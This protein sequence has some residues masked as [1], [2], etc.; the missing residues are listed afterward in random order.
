HFP[1]SSLSLPTYSLF[2]PPP[3][4][5]SLLPPHFSP[6][7]ES[8]FVRK[9]AYDKVEKLLNTIF[10]VSEE[11]VAAATPSVSTPARGLSPPRPHLS[12]SLALAATPSSSNNISLSDP[13]AATASTLTPSLN[14]VSLLSPPSTSHPFSAHSFPS[15]THPSL[16]PPNQS[17]SPSVSSPSISSPTN[18]PPP[19]KSART[20]IPAS[21]PRARAATGSRARLRPPSTPAEGLPIDITVYWKGKLAEKDK[22]LAIERK[23]KHLLGKYLKIALNH[24]G[25][26]SV[27]ELPR[28]PGSGP[29]RDTVAGK[30]IQKLKR[31]LR[32][33]NPL[34]APVAPDIFETKNTEGFILPVKHASLRLTALGVP[35]DKQGEVMS[36]GAQMIG[37]RLSHTPSKT[38]VRSWVPAITAL[39]RMHA[40]EKLEQCKGGATLGRDETTKKGDK[41]QQH[42]VVLGPNQVLFLGFTAVPDKS[43]LVSFDSFR[44][45]IES[46]FAFSSSS[47]PSQ[48]FHSV[49]IKIKNLMS[50]RASTETLF[51]K[52]FKSVR[53]CFLELRE[54]WESLASEEQEEAQSL[55]IHF[56]Q[57]HAVANLY[58]IVSGELV[59]QECESRLHP[60]DSSS[61]GFATV[62]REIPRYLST[63]SAGAHREH[64]EWMEFMKLMGI[65]GGTIP[66]LAGHRFNIHFLIAARVFSLRDHIKKF[67][68]YAPTMAFLNDLLDDEL[69]L[70]QV[71]ILGLLDQKITGPLWRIAENVGVIEGAQ[72]HRDIL[73]YIDDCIDSPALFFSGECPRMTTPPS[74]ELFKV[75]GTLFKALV[76]NSPSSLALEVSVRVLRACATYLRDV[77]SQSLPGG[78]YS[79]P[80]DSV[81]QCVQS[82]TTNRAAESAFAFMDYLYRK[83]PNM[84]F[85]RRDAIT[86]FRLNHVGEW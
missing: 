10:T 67:I 76:T 78:S 19:S 30:E 31:K 74:F 6:G 71:Q 37:V 52:I 20:S 35:D 42:V 47:S 29:P 59:D 25:V 34:P 32:Q 82:P 55:C 26:D 86:C 23:Q 85:F 9:R 24:L 63:R 65:Q 38:T 2:T 62:V 64:K 77:L 3:T 14:R 43:A 8:E 45:K 12:V 16:P 69:V 7:R 73:A 33:K 28:I 5:T 61:A 50:D 80:S 27:K 79:N 70:V 51:N 15:P 53:D 40:A 60:V 57:L 84:R 66:S 13:A 68:E 83:T 44:A 18:G 17:V 72:Y 54:G 58:G 39:N 41:I 1:F 36:I 21:T 4:H 48:L 22:L 75:D 56:C 46:L 11:V 81:A 49:M